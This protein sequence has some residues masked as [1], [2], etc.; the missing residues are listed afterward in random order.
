M[1]MRLVMRL[2]VRRFVGVWALGLLAGG[3]NSSVGVGGRHTARVHL[4]VHVNQTSD[5]ATWEAQT[6]ALARAAAQPSH[7]A[8][9]EHAAWWAAFWGRSRVVVTKARFPSARPSSPPPP[10]LR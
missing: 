9:H 3:G 1:R 5:A 10:P 8:W 2:S 7:A 4:V 6:R